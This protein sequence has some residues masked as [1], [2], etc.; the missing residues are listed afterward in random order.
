MQKKLT[1]TV[2]EDV[3][4]GLHRVIGRGNISRFIEN[5]ARPYLFSKDLEAEYRRMAAD[6]ER[7]K[8]AEEWTEANIDDS[9]S[10]ETW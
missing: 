5:L 4:K 6:T 7:E 10:D 8:E 3:Y 1:I 9:L 2:D